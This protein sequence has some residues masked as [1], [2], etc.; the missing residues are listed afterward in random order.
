M[1]EAYD[2]GADGAIASPSTGTARPLIL[3]SY[4]FKSYSTSYRYPL[5]RLV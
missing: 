2:A 4:S 1:S 3:R 5:G